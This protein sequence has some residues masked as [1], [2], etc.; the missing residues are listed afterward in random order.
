MTEDQAWT[1][2]AHLSKSWT[3]KDSSAGRAPAAAPMPASVPLF[4]DLRTET[5]EERDHLTPLK[6]IPRLLLRARMRRGSSRSHPRSFNW[7]QREASFASLVD[8]SQL[9]SHL[10]VFT[11]ENTMAP[12]LRMPETS[13]Q[14][15]VQ[16]RRGP[17]GLASTSKGGEVV[18]EMKFTCLYKRQRDDSFC[19]ARSMCAPPG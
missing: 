6:R 16:L 19:R 3:S 10:R 14:I 15:Q 5:N 7:L 1:C 17:V 4:H 18:S 2:L 13:K 11:W 8:V 12:N 9:A